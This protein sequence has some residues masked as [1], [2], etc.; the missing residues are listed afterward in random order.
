MLRCPVNIVLHPRAHLPRHL[1]R[2]LVQKH[3]GW[4]YLIT[5]E[6][7]PSAAKFALCFHA[8][9]N[10][11]FRNSFVLKK[12]CVAPCYFADFVF[13]PHNLCSAG[14]ARVHFDTAAP[15]RAV[16]PPRYTQQRSSAI[17][18]LR[19][20]A[21]SPRFQTSGATIAVV[22]LAALRAAGRPLPREW[23]KLFFFQERSWLSA[24]KIQ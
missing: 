4:G 22:F 5:N 2:S 16:S 21:S 24:Q 20:F 18:Y 10:C 13:P 7:S 14:L 23:R 1:L 6:L 11:F 17:N 8:L 12:I 9:T 19:L 15:N 3:P